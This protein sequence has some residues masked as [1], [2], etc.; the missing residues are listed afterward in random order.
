[1]ACSAR[2]QKSEPHE[3]NQESNRKEPRA[4]SPQ[5]KLGLSRA[6]AQRP[7]RSKKMVKFICKKYI[8]SFRT[9]R[10][11]VFAGGISGSESLRLPESLRA[12][13]K[14]LRIAIQSDRPEVCHPERMRGIWERFLPEFTLS[15]AEGV[16]MTNSGL[17]AF[18][19]DN[20]RLPDARSAPYKSLR[21]LRAFV[22]NPVF[23]LPLA[24]VP[25]WD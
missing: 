11:C 4:A 17:G 25:S 15:S 5:P 8:F 10:L 6:K 21:V 12:P 23:H 18:A 19:R 22:V 13:R 7:Q 1:M 14:L 2:P 24:A 16:E 3:R 9:W 20:P